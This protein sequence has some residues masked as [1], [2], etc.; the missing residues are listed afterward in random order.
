MDTK[1]LARYD[2]AVIRQVRTSY[3]SSAYV[4]CWVPINTAI[5]TPFSTSCAVKRRSCR[6]P[7]RCCFEMS[8]SCEGRDCFRRQRFRGVHASAT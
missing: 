1:R 2:D 8:C 5:Q 3:P 7:T 6:E 4:A